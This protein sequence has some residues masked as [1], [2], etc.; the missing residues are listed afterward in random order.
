MFEEKHSYKAFKTSLYPSIE[1]HEDY[2]KPYD[3]VWCCTSCHS[4]IHNGTIKLY[5]QKA[6]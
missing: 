1:P 5:H 6:E 4:K 3:V 2:D